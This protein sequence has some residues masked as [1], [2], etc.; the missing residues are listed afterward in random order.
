MSEAAPL[1]FWMTR[2]EGSGDDLSLACA[3]KGIDIV[4]L[5]LMNIVPLA[6]EGI[7]ARQIMDL[8]HYSHVIFIS[9]N[10][11]R[12]AMPLIEQYWPQ[13]PMGIQWLAIGEATANA[14][15]A[16]DIDAAIAE[17]GMDSESLLLL[18][19]LRVGQ[20]G[21]RVLIMRGQGGRE[22]LA[23]A[24]RDRG[25]VVDYC[26]LYQRQ[27]PVY[28]QGT[29]SHLLDEL[30]INC[31]LASSAETLQNGLALASQEGRQ[32]LL[33]LPVVVPSE[34][35]EKIALHS[36]CQRVVRAS[37]AG[38]EAVVAALLTLKG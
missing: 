7:A 20:S 37:N 10:A 29:L 4:Q 8:D 35:V 28:P 31:W 36:G 24:L 12:F 21:Q 16:Y 23:S 6:D 13:L 11:V 34:R 26:E 19:V 27:V 32:E 2:P 5:P 30:G 33:Q 25:W 18:D 38:S 1:H 3:A 22:F 9:T 14:L 17:T 15:L